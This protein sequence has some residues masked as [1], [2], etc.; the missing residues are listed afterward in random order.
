MVKLTKEKQK[1]IL[2]L[3]GNKGIKDIASQFDVTS[4]YVRKVLKNERNN[5]KIFDAVIK[6][7]I[8]ASNKQDIKIK[9]VKSIL[10]DI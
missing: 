6:L 10:K 8:E 3:I 9:E 4:D 7:S 1:K 2:G 5:E